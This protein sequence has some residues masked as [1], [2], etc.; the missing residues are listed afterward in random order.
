MKIL[1]LLMPI[2]LCAEN[3]DTGSFITDYEYGEMLYN[4]PRGVSCSECHGKVGEGKTI[5]QYQDIHG[6]QAIKGS[7]IRKSTLKEM[8][9]AVN[10]Y[11]KVMPRYYLTRDEM[12]AMYDYLQIKNKEYLNKK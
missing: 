3:N 4:N 5:V 10:S 1:W 9:A 12:K 8:I 11:H 2:F 6:K 7:D